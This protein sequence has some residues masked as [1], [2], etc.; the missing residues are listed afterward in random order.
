[1]SWD[2]TGRTPKSHTE[3]PRLT[4]CEASVLTTAPPCSPHQN[5]TLHTTIRNNSVPQTPKSKMWNSYC[6]CLS[7]AEV[8]LDGLLKVNLQWF[9]NCQLSFKSLVHIKLSKGANQMCR[10]LFSKSIQAIHQ[11]FHLKSDQIIYASPV[12][13]CTPPF[14]EMQM[15][16]DTEH[17]V[18]IQ[19]LSWVGRST[20]VGAS[21]PESK[22][23]RLGFAL[24]FYNYTHKSS[25]LVYKH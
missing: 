16:M 22:R 23:V 3:R 10:W 15:Q 12:S 5:P 4:S 14:M 7:Q 25:S 20:L 2:C 11:V 21:L 8:L 9:K 24:I 1:M 6:R 18:K 17:L 13:Y 19:E